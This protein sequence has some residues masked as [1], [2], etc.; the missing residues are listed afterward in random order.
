MDFIYVV[1]FSPADA[2]PQDE[3]ASAYLLTA[4]APRTRAG[5]AGV[6]AF[7]QWSPLPPHPR[8]QTRVCRLKGLNTYVL[9]G[10][11]SL[12]SL[13]GLPLISSSSHHWLQELSAGKGDHGTEIASC[14]A[15]GSWTTLREDYNSQHAPRRPAS[16][17]QKAAGAQLMGGAFPTCPAAAGNRRI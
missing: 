5:Q 16:H 9:D 17:S 10:G 4:P 13:G 7:Q 15:S 8:K 11:H 14:S 6:R 3:H 1:I 12:N 2:R